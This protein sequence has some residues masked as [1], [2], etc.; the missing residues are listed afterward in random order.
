MR[1]ILLDLDD[2]LLDDRTATRNA[3]SAFLVA[4]RPAWKNESEEEALLR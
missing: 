4:H 1:G 3:L 2:T